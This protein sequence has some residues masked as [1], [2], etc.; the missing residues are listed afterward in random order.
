LKTTAR[1]NIA[2][3]AGELWSPFGIAALIGLLA[4]VAAY[5][6][7]IT[8]FFK[9]LAARPYY[10]HFPFVLAA[11]AWL[12]IQR[13]VA[14]RPN[15]RDTSATRL[16]TFAAV[17]LFVAWAT[18]AMAYVGNSPWLAYF[19]LVMLLG[20]GLAIASSAWHIDG[21]VGIWLLLWLIIPLPLGRDQQ[22][23][24][25]LQR[26]SS[27]A[28]SFAMD[29]VGVAHLMEGNALTL[30]NKQLFVDEACSGIVSVMSII[31]CAAIFG[32]WRRRPAAHVIALILAGVAW[33][34][35][36]NTFRISGIAVALDKWGVDWS[37]GTPHQILSLVIFMV[38]FLALMSTDALLVGLLAPIAADWE[39]HRGGP[40]GWGGRIVRFW[41]W[42]LTVEDLEEAADTE[43]S[44]SVEQPCALR[45]G[46]WHSRLAL[47]VAF[48]ALPV[49]QLVR[50]SEATPV[51]S[52]LATVRAQAMIQRA[53][54]CD[55]V[56][57]PEKVGSLL[58]E[59]FF[60]VE[61]ERN[62]LLGNYSRCHEYRDADGRSFLVS[63]DFPY[64]GGWHE[65]TDCYLG[66]GWEVDDRRLG[67]D[68]SPGR[69][70][71]WQ[72]MEADLSKPDG[73]KAF[74]TACAFDECGVPIDL[75][76][77]SFAADVWNALSVQRT[78]LPRQIAF[79]VQVF[80]ASS[81]PIGAQQRQA[82]HELMLVARDQFRM[83]IV[84]GAEH[85]S[86]PRIGSHASAD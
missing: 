71:P 69:D 73:T 40:V 85:T 50:D 68:A 81:Q 25:L 74:V 31:A 26:L 53:R 29:A 28:S 77:R 33:A 37:A 70:G 34:T 30:P 75:P 14:A 15:L 79:Q 22:I 27:R 3:R 46:S 51:N 86:V 58:R 64:E 2:S 44:S 35:V 48:V 49:W 76:T 39:L 59:R 36:M 42:L 24:T 20:G 1:I 55:A 61:R 17:L 78:T 21:V 47:L 32:V 9:N 6:T 4:V 38:T 18:L 16:Q 72:R 80:I 41:D 52:A 10:Q 54:A 82:A 65:L 11:F 13:G 67:A 8:E 84:D 83:L 12:L 7:L 43:A 56:F 60:P 57:L 23:V 5:G 19:S 63:C 62:D 66:M 45:N